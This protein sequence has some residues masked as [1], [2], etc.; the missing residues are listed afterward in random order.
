MEPMFRQNDNVL[1]VNWGKIIKGSVVVFK[2][3]DIYIIKR[4]KHLKGDRLII[5]ADNKKLAKKEWNLGQDEIVGRVF[6][7]Y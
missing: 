4:V 5:G 7:K 1:T 6:L 3:D 2:E